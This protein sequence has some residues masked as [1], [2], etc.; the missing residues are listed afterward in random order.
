MIS[1]FMISINVFSFLK[2][3]FP[4]LSAHLL[5]LTASNHPYW[6]QAYMN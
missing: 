5:Y 3:Y 4:I 1:L 2:Y 6:E